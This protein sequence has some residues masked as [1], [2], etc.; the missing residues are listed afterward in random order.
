M[1]KILTANLPPLTP[2]ESI[3]SGIAAVELSA[4]ELDRITGGYNTEPTPGVCLTRRP[5]GS[6]DAE[7]DR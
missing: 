3:A 7:A 1:N 6:T 4:K 2:R 5:D